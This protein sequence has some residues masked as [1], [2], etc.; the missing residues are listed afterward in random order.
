MENEGIFRALLN[1]TRRNFRPAPRQFSAEEA[2]D[3]TARPPTWMMEVRRDKIWEQF[4]KARQIFEQGHVVWGHLIQANQIL[5]EEG[6]DDA[7]AAWLYSADPY[8]EEDVDSLGAIAHGLF[9]TKGKRTGDREVQRFADMLHDERERQLRLPIPKSMTGGRAVTYTCGMIVRKHLPLP[10]LADAL[11]PLVVAPHV[12]E[13][14]WILPSRYW[15]DDL[16]NHW[17]SALDQ[18]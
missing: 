1:S 5:F 6:P 13:A 12:S 4:N 9:E 7:P 10:F 15:A 17:F 3:L 16:L 14:T 11:F 18:Q 8:F 2:R